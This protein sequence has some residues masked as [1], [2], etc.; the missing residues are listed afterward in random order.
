MCCGVVK[1]VAFAMS[2]SL[3]QISPNLCV[4]LI[5]C[6]LETSKIR[7]FGSEIGCCVKIEIFGSTSFAVQK[8]TLFQ[9]KRIELCHKI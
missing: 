8:F 5:V 6:D 1:V 3:I 2:L 9:D 7:R 4:C